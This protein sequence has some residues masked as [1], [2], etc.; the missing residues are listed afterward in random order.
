[1]RKTLWRTVPVILALALLLFP[2]GGDDEGKFSGRLRSLMA[3]RGEAG[4]F[5]AWV[6]FRDKGPDSLRSMEEAEASL[7]ARARLRRLRHRSP[8]N[9]VDGFDVP[10]YGPYVERLRPLARRIRHRSRWLNAVSLEARG[11]ALREIAAFGFVLR[12]EA[13]GSDTWHEPDWS[14]MIQSRAPARSLEAH[15]LD[16]G[17]SMNQLQLM[18]VPA[19]HDRGLSGRGVLICMLDSGF[20]ALDHEA[21]D[22][23]DIVGTWDFVNDDPVVADETGQMG[24]GDHGTATLGTLAGFEPGELIGPAYNASFLLGKTENTTWERHIE[25]DHW[26]AGA[27]WA[28]ERGADIISSSVGYRHQFSHGE[29]GY[30]WEDMDGQTAVI[31]KAANIAA[32]RG[33]LVVNSAGN[34]GDDFHP[35]NSLIAPADSPTVLAVGAVNYAG[36]RVD[37]S[38]VG[39]TADGRIKPDV[40]AQGVTVRAPLPDSSNSYG[41]VQGTSFSCPLAAGAAALVLEAHPAWTNLEIIQALKATA[42]HALSPDNRHGW[43]VVDAEEASSYTPRSFFAPSDFAIQRLENDYIFFVQYVD[44]LTW[45]ENPLNRG[46]VKGYR[47]YSRPIA[48]PNLAFELLTEVG[49]DTFTLDRRGLLAD[50]IF[51][52]RINAVDESGEESE[53]AYAAA[54]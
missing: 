32:S 18:R 51:I 12:L 35:R 43:G 20:N 3:E 2:Q 6:F 15:A 38:S 34:E 48:G 10:V 27:E 4:V 31:T 42:S 39:P 25:E 1:M 24:N 14:S 40:M 45:R 21:L 9:L 16:Y 30:G 7:S 54:R 5:T 19:L 33:I 50:E 26:V 41:W 28:D 29:T 13:V 37:F 17:N 11:R 47:I 52:Y 23:L 46:A 44:R 8:D 53:A 36:V 49:S 22:H